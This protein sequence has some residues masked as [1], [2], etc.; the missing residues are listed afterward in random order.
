MRP[1]FL[2]IVCEATNV[3]ILAQK[4]RDCRICLSAVGL[5]RTLN[6]RVLI[7][8]ATFVIPADGHCHFRLPAM[9]FTERGNLEEWKGW[10][11][12]SLLP[13]LPC[14]IWRGYA[15]ALQSIEAL[16]VKLG[17]FLP[18]HLWRGGERGERP[19]RH[20]SRYKLVDGFASHRGDASGRIGY[21]KPSL[22]YSIAARRR[23]QYGP[24][25]ALFAHVVSLLSKSQRNFL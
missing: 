18:V 3:A 21:S 12:A 6:S 23:H 2:L 17:P 10:C 22:K 4:W 15:P 14:S 25:Y 7:Y 11:C 5:G 20:Q 16:S 9:L 8:A 1:R 19:A 24:Y 13:L